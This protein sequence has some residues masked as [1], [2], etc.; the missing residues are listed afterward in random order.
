MNEFYL[1]EKMIVEIQSKVE[2]YQELYGSS[3]SVD[4]LNHSFPECFSKIQ[5]ALFFEIICR[6]SALFDP[7]VSG[8]NK[9]LTLDYLVLLSE[10]SCTK[11]RRLELESI[12][13]DFQGTGL[14]NIRNKLYAHND[15]KT[16]MGKRTFTN[17]IT[18]ECMNSLL[19]RS[20]SFVR[21]LGVE[22]NKIAKDQVIV[23]TKNLP[24]GRNGKVLVSR[25]KNT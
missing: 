23:R 21:N 10:D 12:K 17:E 6:T 22:T 3:Q 4:V 9:N 18:Y 25:L 19:C 2:L 15:H 16:Y 14:K 13:F 1:L 5:E 24:K 11:E 8:K 20:F 7:A